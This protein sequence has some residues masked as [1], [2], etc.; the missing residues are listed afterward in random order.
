MIPGS[1]VGAIVGVGAGLKKLG[2]RLGREI[3]T[4]GNTVGLGNGEYPEPPGFILPDPYPDPH[5]HRSRSRSGPV[6]IQ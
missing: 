6:P 3:G 4:S 2:G 1:K 5:W